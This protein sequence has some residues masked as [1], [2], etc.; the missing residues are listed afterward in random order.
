MY[1]TI[2][3]TSAT[4]DHIF[5]PHTT[6]E[7]PKKH[8]E[9]EPPEQLPNALSPINYGHSRHSEDCLWERATQRAFW[10]I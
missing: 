2:S 1:L 6:R 5:Y 7:L 3:V 9:A 10:K 4:S 8:D